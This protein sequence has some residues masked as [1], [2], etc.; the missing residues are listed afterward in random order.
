[1]QL[2]YRDAK[3]IEYNA[4]YGKPLILS[5]FEPNYL[6]KHIEILIFNQ[7]KCLQVKFISLHFVFLSAL[8]IFVK[9]LR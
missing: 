9:K 2:V 1:M 3:E 4:I 6:S 8:V 5:T 7:E